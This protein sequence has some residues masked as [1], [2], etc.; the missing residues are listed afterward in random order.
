MA[1]FLVKFQRYFRRRPVRF[2][3]L[4]ALYL[5]AGS[6]VFLHAGFTGE[7]RVAGSPRGPAAGEGQELPYL[8][9][10]QLS[11]SFPGAAGGRRRGPWFKSTA[12]E[13][14]ERSK[15][16]DYGAARSRLLKGRSG[17]EKD[18][19]RG[20]GWRR[21]WGKPRAPEPWSPRCF[22]AC[23]PMVRW[24]RKQGNVFCPYPGVLCAPGCARPVLETPGAEDDAPP[25]S[26][27]PKYQLST[28]IFPFS[29]SCSGLCRAVTV[30]GTFRAASRGDAAGEDGS[31]RSA[32]SSRCPLEAQH[33]ELRLWGQQLPARSGSGSVVNEHGEANAVSRIDF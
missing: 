30:R 9:V 23:I 20:K 4:L 33:Q 7:P 5:A 16:G 3:T 18:E 17:R 21:A 26:P 19:D 6:L 10:M 8:G 24:G 31:G 32:P 28:P 29:P 2:F 12:K 15:V 1:K 14:A 27:L 22:W 13:P 11:R 25:L